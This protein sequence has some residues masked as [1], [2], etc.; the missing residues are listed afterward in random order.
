[1]NKTELA[2]R[3]CGQW[4][5]VAFLTLLLA[6]CGADSDGAAEP[7]GELH[8]CDIAPASEVSR[9]FGIPV[10][11]AT[12][13]MESASGKNAFSQCSYKFDGGG[14]GLSVQISRSGA[15]QEHSRQADADASRKKKDSL[16]IG[17]DV[18]NAI[19]AGT[20]IRGLG[21]IAY[22]FD[23]NGNYQQ[24]V[25]YWNDYYQLA[26]ISFGGSDAGNMAAARQ[27]LARYI[28]DTL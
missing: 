8:A 19:E 3:P 2:Q 11:D 16:G 14:M 15:K 12:P 10:S 20:D 5:A 17:E 4:V 9:I 21:D 25:V 24:L 22:D 6:S 28:V 7:S 27:A 1:M 23:D 18:A 13:S 26:I